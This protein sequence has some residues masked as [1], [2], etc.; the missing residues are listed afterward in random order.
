VVVDIQAH[1]C[2]SRRVPPYQEDFEGSGG[3]I[4]VRLEPNN[5]KSV[6]N[7]GLQYDRK[8][9]PTPIPQALV[10]PGAVFVL[11]LT[12]PV[13]PLLFV[14]C[15]C[16]SSIVPHLKVVF[17]IAAIARI[18]VDL[19]E[20]WLEVLL[21]GKAERPWDMIAV[22]NL[23]II[24]YWQLSIRNLEEGEPAGLSAAAAVWYLRRLRHWR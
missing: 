23:M 2:E 12:V 3:D 22:S 5:A 6:F 11:Q 18:Q 9:P 19:N 7:I 4:W 8:E 14:S 13:S 17:H 16:F 21:K 20:K 1:L 24:G 15:S 10:D